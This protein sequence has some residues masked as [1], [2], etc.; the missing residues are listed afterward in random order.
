MQLRV[1]SGQGTWKS[2]MKVNHTDSTCTANLMQPCCTIM[3]LTWQ[4][5]V[6]SVRN[7]RNFLFQ[8]GADSNPVIAG[9]CNLPTNNWPIFWIWMGDNFLCLY[10]FRLLRRCFHSEH[11]LN[12]PGLTCCIHPCL[13]AFPALILKIHVSLS[14]P[15]TSHPNMPLQRLS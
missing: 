3:P 12:S 8:L 15:S 7:N 4:H 5:K 14:F 1:K 10:L 11:P 9:S 13:S 2:L 6:E